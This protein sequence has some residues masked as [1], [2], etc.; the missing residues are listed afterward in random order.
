MLKSGILLATAL[1]VAVS[2]FA[3]TNTSPGGTGNSLNIPS[4]QGIVAK[5]LTDLD[6]SKNKPG[7][8]V[9]AQILRDLKQGHNTLLRKGSTLSGHIAKVQTLAGN[10]PSTIVLVFDHVTPAGGQTETLNVLIGALAPAVTTQTE[11]LQ[12]G[13][14]MEQTNINSVVG[15]DKDLGVAGELTATSAGVHGIPG[16][17]LASTV[18]AGKQ[19]SVIQSTNG[20]VKIKKGSQVV[21]KT[22]AQ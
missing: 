19:Y 18:E 14:G 8:A 16:T 20:N 6:A 10:A 21:F 11:S 4:T 12:D 17:S 15:G 13:R 3:Q 22:A 5:L 2:S 9:Q 7:D 1:A